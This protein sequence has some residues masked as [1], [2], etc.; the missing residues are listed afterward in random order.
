M[1]FEKEEDIVS[2]AE[3]MARNRVAAEVVPDKIV[4]WDHNT[5]GGAYER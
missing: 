3:A 4:R 1:D 2:I 5:L